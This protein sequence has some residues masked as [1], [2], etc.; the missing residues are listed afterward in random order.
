[1]VAYKKKK[2]TWYFNISLCRDTPWKPII[3]GFEQLCT[4]VNSQIKCTITSIFHYL[5]RSI[6][7]LFTLSPRTTFFLSV[8][9]LNYILWELC[10]WI[11][12]T[13]VQNQVFFFIKVELIDIT[14]TFLSPLIISKLWKQRRQNMMYRKLHLLIVR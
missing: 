13:L 4:L 8:F 3:T 2:N 9:S 1:M 11:S 12:E 14:V 7:G 5:L 6:G 10:T